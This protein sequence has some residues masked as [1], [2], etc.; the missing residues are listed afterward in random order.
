[1]VAAEAY[2]AVLKDCV[3]LMKEDKAKREAMARHRERYGLD[4]CWFE[5]VDQDLLPNCRAW[6][7]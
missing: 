6:L 4:F 3:A 5:D 7:D 2:L 1:M